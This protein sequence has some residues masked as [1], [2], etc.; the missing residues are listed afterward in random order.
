MFLTMTVQSA[1]PTVEPFDPA[2]VGTL[3]NPYANGALE[4]MS[5]L[6]VEVL[7]QTTGQYTP[8]VNAVPGA[9]EYDLFV[10]ALNIA[11]IVQSPN[12][13]CVD[14][15]RFRALRVDGTTLEFR[16]CLNQA[17]ILRGPIPGLR[18]ADLP[19]GPYFIDILAPYLP[20]AYRQLLGV[21]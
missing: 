15:V 7:D 18:G 13:G 10:T 11:T 9:P 4:G 17:V 8:V 21:Q 1:L 6:T 20:P 14:H 5:S 2:V 19:M 12:T 3:L 16:A